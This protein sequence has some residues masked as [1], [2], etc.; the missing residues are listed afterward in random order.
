MDAAQDLRSQF[1]D[2]L[3]DDP[4]PRGVIHELA[5]PEPAP[6]KQD[7]NHIVATVAI[8]AMAIGAFFAYRYFVV[9]SSCTPSLPT[10][11]VEKE[12]S[13]VHSVHIEPDPYAD[14]LFE[15]L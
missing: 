6:S 1:A 13:E 15:P 11:I 14:P 12:Q 7:A 5:V 9:L 10:D 8:V 3:T 4:G 2:L